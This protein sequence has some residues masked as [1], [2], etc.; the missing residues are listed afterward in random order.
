MAD[1]RNILPPEK[2]AEPQVQSP[3]IYVK[4]EVRWEYKRIERHLDREGAPSEADLNDL[5]AEGWELVSNFSHRDYIY[6]IFKRQA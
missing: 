5:G 2:P 4:E 6:L 1:Y 3:M